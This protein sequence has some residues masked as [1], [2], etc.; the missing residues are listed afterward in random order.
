MNVKNFFDKDTSTLSYVV[1]D[2]ITKDCLVIDPVLNFDLEESTFSTKSIDQVYKFIKKNNLQDR[3]SLNIFSIDNLT[4][5]DYDD[6][7]GI[8]D[9]DENKYIISI[10][11]S[12][13]NL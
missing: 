8:Q 7:I 13:V 4:T 1:F 11:I 5:T 6:A 3:R 2:K 12:N 9:L 10:Y